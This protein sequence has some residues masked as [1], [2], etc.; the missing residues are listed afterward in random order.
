MRLFIELPV[1][2]DLMNAANLLDYSNLIKIDFS[3]ISEMSEI[4]SLLS[5]TNKSI[6]APHSNFLYK[7]M[8]IAKCFNRLIVDEGSNNEECMKFF[9]AMSSCFLDDYKKGMCF[10]AIHWLIFSNGAPAID[11]SLIEE[12]TKDGSGGD[13]SSKQNW[14]FIEIYIPKECYNAYVFKGNKSK[15][16]FVL[17]PPYTIFKVGE[18][19]HGHIRLI[20]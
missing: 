13:K 8:K 6:S 16:A 12:E 14:Y 15:L 1:I 11:R 2:F 19:E 20:V 10:Q 9:G 17:I 18:K 3:T 4:T 7:T 5:T